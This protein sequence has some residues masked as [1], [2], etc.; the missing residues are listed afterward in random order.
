MNYH[1]NKH[2]VFSGRGGKYSMAKY[3]ALVV[4]QG[5]IGAGLVQFLPTV[6][7]VSAAVIKIPLTLCFLVSA[8][9]SSATLCLI[10]DEDER[11]SK[12]RRRVRTRA[13]LF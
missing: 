8:T 3:Y 7:P 2:T 13:A 4:I 5:L 6:L 11:K 9:L 12:A 10:N 1:L